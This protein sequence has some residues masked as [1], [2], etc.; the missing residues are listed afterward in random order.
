MDCNNEKNKIKSNSFFFKLDVIRFRDDYNMLY[1][2]L[3]YVHFQNI[4][5]TVWSLEA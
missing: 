3:K 2:K 5:W 4:L 1:I